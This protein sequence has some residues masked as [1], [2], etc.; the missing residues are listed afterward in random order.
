MPPC[1]P[2]TPRR[3]QA[4][5]GRNDPRMPYGPPS[6]RQRP[7]LVR[8]T[9]LRIPDLRSRHANIRQAAHRP[10][11]PGRVAATGPGH[12]HSPPVTRA[13][14]APTPHH[15]LLAA[16][17]KDAS[18][19]ATRSTTSILDPTTH[20]RSLA[21]IRGREQTDLRPNS[22]NNPVNSG[23]TMTTPYPHL[24]EPFHIRA[25]RRRPARRSSCP[26]GSRRSLRTPRSAVT[27]RIMAVVYFIPTPRAP[28]GG[29]LRRHGR[30][31]EDGQQDIGP[32]G[33]RGGGRAV[34][35]RGN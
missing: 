15:P 22:P 13:L 16:R 4:S 30:V 21:P 24:T 5:R 12:H 27:G 23:Q 6:Q 19:V 34:R 11:T 2:P 26:A 17:V 32:R 7:H 31:F 1:A 29:S 18:G 14:P 3:V 25:V 10:A 28:Y 33:H 8:G 35:R 9:L 20:P